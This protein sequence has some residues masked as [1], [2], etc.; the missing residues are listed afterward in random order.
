[1][2]EADGPWDFKS[3]DKYKSATTS[4]NGTGCP[5]EG[6]DN[7]VTICG[8]CFDYDV[9]G[10]IHYGWVGRMAG[11]R[12]WLLH[13]GADWAQVR[14]DILSGEGDDPKDK[15]AVDIGEDLADGGGGDICAPILAHK[16]ELRRGPSD[17]KACNL[18]YTGN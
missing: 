15:V 10:N 9:P 1:M 17:C 18:K 2:V 7:T 13:L 16:N 5:S 8:A 4:G 14:W 11:W 12:D 6:C 3:L